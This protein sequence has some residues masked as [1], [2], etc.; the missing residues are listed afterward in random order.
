MNHTLEQYFQDQSLYKAAID[1]YRRDYIDNPHRDWALT[2]T[3]GKFT[4][5]TW[6][7]QVIDL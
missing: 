3:Y 1:R 6:A 4:A 2:G 7:A 5:Y